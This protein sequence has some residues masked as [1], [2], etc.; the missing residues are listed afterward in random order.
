[1][2][3]KNVL[4]SRKFLSFVFVLSKYMLLYDAL[5]DRIGEKGVR[6]GKARVLNLCIRCSD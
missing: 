4:I 1:M 6:L 2:C 3:E 5:S